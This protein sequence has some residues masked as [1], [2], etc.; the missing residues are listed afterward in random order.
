MTIQIALVGAGRIGRIHADNIAA[1]PRARIAYVFDP[2]RENAERLSR[3]AAGVYA[4]FEDLLARGDV[5][6]FLIASP[7]TAHVAQLSAISAT[8]K[9]VLC[10]KPLSF[11][12]SD[13]AR[14]LGHFAERRSRVMMGFHRRYDAQFR[15][16]RRRIADGALGQICQI[17]ISSHSAMVPSND[18]LASSGGLFRD[19]SIHDFDMA[20][21]LTGEEFAS[22]YAVGGCLI[23]ARVAEVGDIDTAMITM[24]AESGCQVHINNG[25]YHPGGYDQRIEVLATNGSA[26][27]ENV[28]SRQEADNHSGEAAQPATFDYFLER[29]RDAF[30][31]EL[32]AFLDFVEGSGE[33]VADEMDGYRAQELAEAALR[34]LR[35]RSAVDVKKEFGR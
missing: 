4:N 29:Y 11:D 9:P 19:Q 26:M 1:N 3:L 32:D 7:A 33:P 23:E 34:S 25:R 5:D 21:F 17:T 35:S 18:Y 27:I 31:A 6:A 8:G 24:V 14:L 10:E 15:T 13:S 20:R 12:L 16:L 28:W 30:R 22:L 2:Q